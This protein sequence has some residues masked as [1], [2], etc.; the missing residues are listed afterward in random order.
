MPI[1]QTKPLEW[2]KVKKQVRE[3]FN[4]QELRQLGMSLKDRQL[5][6]VLALSDG[7]LVAGERRYRAALLVGLDALD[8]IIADEGM[9]EAEIKRW[10]LVENMQRENLT[11]YEQ[12]INSY[13]LLTMNQWQLKDL[14]EALGITPASATRIMSPSKTTKEWQEALKEGK[15]TISDCYAAS[16]VEKSEQNSM[17]ALKLNGASRDD[18]ETEGRK[19]R[20]GNKDTVKTSRIR[21]DISC[22]MA[23]TLTGINIGLHEFIEA[24]GEALR[25]ARKA[26][27]SGLDVK[28]F[29]CV[30]RDKAKKG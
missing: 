22:G 2:F 9:T 16:K 13:E 5:Q 3:H 17:L 6:P 19:R 1:L 25:D 30:Q 26:R 11:G 15:V 12:W 28:T 27:D 14:A 4:E 20:N 23:V 8:V 7:T 10:Q 29:V 18:L 24:L 21:C